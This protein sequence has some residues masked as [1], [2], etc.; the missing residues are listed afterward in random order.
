MNGNAMETAAEPPEM[1]A[2]LLAGVTLTNGW[3]VTKKLSTEDEK[4]SPGF[5]SVGYLAEKGAEKAFLKAFDLAAV[6]QMN[7]TGADPG[8]MMVALQQLSSAF[9]AEDALLKFCSASKLDRIVRAIGSGFA[10]PPEDVRVAA[11]YPVPYLLFELAD[12]DIRKFV[13]KTDR[14][15]DAWR[16][17]HLHDVAVGLQQLHTHRIAH[18][19]LKPA[20]VLVFP[21]EGAKIAD[22]G[23]A[24]RD[25]VPAPHDSY[26]VPGDFR[27]APPE[28][29]Y[30]ETPTSWV[31]RREASDLY[32]LGSLMTFVFTGMAVNTSLEK[33]IPDSMRPGVWR[34]RYHEILPHVNAAFTQ[35]LDEVG[36][37]FPEWARSDLVMLLRQMCHP[38]YKLRGAPSARMQVKSPIGMDRFVSHFDRLAK[39]AALKMRQSQ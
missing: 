19:D 23:R 2:R 25:G 18:Q 6:M 39:M 29:R 9:T 4:H 21:T 1:P 35:V 10:T 36:P 8:A 37:Q 30:G 32:H 14:A 11:P 34:G 15:E 20:N 7:A 16:F 22:L 26:P 38:D 17:R 28:L 24:S 13:G 3:K 12:G 33:Y 31:D 27:Y 5:F